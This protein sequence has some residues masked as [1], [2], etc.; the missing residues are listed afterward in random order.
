MKE[1][2]LHANELLKLL[3]SPTK[4]LRPD[5]DDLRHT[6]RTRAKTSDIE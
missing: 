6:G 3:S 5:N 2:S 4:D 1:E